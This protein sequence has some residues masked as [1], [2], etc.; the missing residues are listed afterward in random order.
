MPRE[1]LDTSEH[2]G[3]VTRPQMSCVLGLE[4]GTW[5]LGCGARRG[6]GKRPARINAGPRQGNAL[7]RQRNRLPC[8]A[9]A[10]LNPRPKGFSCWAWGPSDLGGGSS[11]PPWKP[12]DSGPSLEGPRSQGGGSSGRDRRLELPAICQSAH[13]VP[14]C[15]GSLRRE[16][17]AAQQARKQ[18]PTMGQAVRMKTDRTCLSSSLW[19]PGAAHRRARLT[20]RRWGELW[21]CPA[22]G[23]AGTQGLVRCPLPPLPIH[24]FTPSFSTRCPRC[25]G[26]AGRGWWSLPGWGS[27]PP[28]EG[29]GKELGT[30]ASGPEADMLPRRVQGCAA[31]PIQV[32]ARPGPH[33]SVL[34]APSRPW[35]AVMSL[36]SLSGCFSSLPTLAVRGSQHALFHLPAMLFPPPHPTQ[37]RRSAQTALRRA[38][39]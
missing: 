3:E 8:G 26:D 35:G 10:S 4:W 6:A 29:R 38:V 1:Q 16:D 20:K 7:S 33:L 23:P 12:S 15:L 34:P 5:A 39:S 30:V 9:S 13:L 27:Q 25:W 14:R 19:A 36:P 11:H 2:F 18:G 28:R 24:S 22:P 32:K 31:R 21:L 37:H 17:R